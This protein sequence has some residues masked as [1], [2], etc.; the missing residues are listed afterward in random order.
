MLTFLCDS[1]RS[2][3]KWMDSV[4]NCHPHRDYYVLLVLPFHNHNRPS[5]VVVGV[6]KSSGGN[7]LGLLSC[8]MQQRG[9]DP[10]LPLNPLVEGIFPLKL[11]WVLTPFPKTLSHE[12]INRGLVCAHMHSIAWPQKILT[13]MSSTGECR[14]QKH[15]QDA[16]SIKTECEYLYGHIRKNVTQ[17]GEPQR[18]SWERRRRRG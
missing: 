13:F 16:P 3:S 12:S 7:V 17:N 4:R 6:R 14:Q 8:I 15:T 10:P 9:F 18:Y 1:N 2:N 11:P 5:P